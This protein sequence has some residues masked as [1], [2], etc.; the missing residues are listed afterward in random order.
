M[1]TWMAWMVCAALALP[2]QAQITETLEKLG[3]K[4]TSETPTD[5]DNKRPKPKKQ[6][7]LLLNFNWNGWMNQPAGM[8]VSPF[9]RG[10][11]V[12]I[13]SDHPLGRSN[14]SLAW[15][16]GIGTE[17]IFTN[18]FLRRNQGSDSV[19]WDDISARINPDSALNSNN[20]RDWGKYK[21]G[22]VLIELPL[23][24]RFRL[25]PSKRGTFKMAAGFKIGYV[26]DSKDKY[27]GPDYRYDSQGNQSMLNQ[28]LRQKTFG[29][30]GINRFRYAVYGRMGWGRWGFTFQYGLQPFFQS[31]IGADDVVPFQFGLTLLPF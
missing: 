3:K 23:E 11:D 27:V 30:P 25:K 5:E 24:V 31:G 9:S 16:L 14:F 8:D 4:K 17:N 10:F 13:M 28:E 1:K 6:D 21:L 19:Y 2:A 22:T 29:L 18:A 7:F 15:G 26:M 12:A 20:L